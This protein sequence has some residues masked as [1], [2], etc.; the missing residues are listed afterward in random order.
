MPSAVSVSEAKSSRLRSFLSFALS[1]AYP[2]LV[3][4]RMKSVILLD[5]PVSGD[6]A[7]EKDGVSCSRKKPGWCFLRPVHSSREIFLRVEVV[8]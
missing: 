5:V 7:R 1:N 3:S 2:A 6:S 4:V 8:R